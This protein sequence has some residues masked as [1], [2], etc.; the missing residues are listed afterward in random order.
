MTLSEEDGA[1]STTLQQP[2]VK[3]QLQDDG[4][5]EGKLT[6]GDSSMTTVATTAGSSS[7]SSP[8]AATTSLTASNDETTKGDDSRGRFSASGSSHKHHHHHENSMH[9]IAQLMREQD[10]DLL[11]SIHFSTP[12]D[13][14]GETPLISSRQN[15]RLPSASSYD[16]GSMPELSLTPA[17]TT[18]AGGSSGDA[19]TSSS[20]LNAPQQA[21]FLTP[22][23]IEHVRKLVRKESGEILEEFHSTLVAL[24]GGSAGGSVD[25]SGVARMALS[26]EIYTLEDDVAVVHQRQ[27]HPQQLLPLTPVSPVKKNL[28]DASTSG[29]INEQGGI[30]NA[31]DLP[32]IPEKDVAT[33]TVELATNSMFSKDYEPS[34]KRSDS[35]DRRINEAARFAEAVGDIAPA[36]QSALRIIESDQDD[37]DDDEATEVHVELEQKEPPLSRGVLRHGSLDRRRSE[38]AQ[39]AEAVGGLAP[40]EQDEFRIIEE[41]Q[42]ADVDDDDD[43]DEDATEIHVEPGKTPDESIAKIASPAGAT[44]PAT[45]KRQKSRPQWPFQQDTS[46]PGFLVKLPQHGPKHDFEYKGIRANPPDIVKSG[47]ERGN[48]AQLHRKAWLEVSDKYHRYGKNLRLYYRYWERLGFPTNMFFDW[49]DSKGEAAGQPLPELEECPRSELDSDTVLYI[50]NPE[51]TK[52]YALS[53]TADEFGRAKVFDVDGDVVTTGS[54]G[55]IFVLRD[56]VMYGAQKITSVS[57]HSKQ[58]F[59]HSSFFGGKAVAVAGIFISDDEGFLTR[60]YPHSGH[61]R[62]GESHMQRM[63]FF[64]HNLGVDLWTFD[65]DMQQV[66]HIARDNPP[67][68]KKGSGTGQDNTEKAEKKKKTESLYLVAGTLAACYLAHKARFIGAGIFKQIHM[69]RKAGVTSVTEALEAIDDGTAVAQY[70]TSRQSATASFMTD[71]CNSHSNVDNTVG[72]PMGSQ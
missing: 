67:P 71:I 28:V 20:S 69:I 40:A 45:L 42:D 57:G 23:T 65:V 62:P 70:Q 48:Y 5:N 37:E 29:S 19:P 33:E 58:R 15:S 11:D 27:P 60:L 9:E 35:V 34:I 46:K 49:L 66:L 8:H 39:F 38:A 21:H 22:R 18:P 56:N 6:G 16:F 47:K 1:S 4:M 51:V 44:V 53:F 25:A 54:E 68:A 32:I 50:T 31:P 17:A 3:Q 2:L 36:E 13:S 61:Y 26:G 24:G 10:A 64:L 12:N 41:D 30:T 72:Q 59:H 63:L 7:S 55:W 14:A 52:G 43:D